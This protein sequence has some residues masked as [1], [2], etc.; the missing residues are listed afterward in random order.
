MN[1]LKKLKTLD[2]KA[3]RLNV[4]AGETYTMQREA[5]R[6]PTWL[7]CYQTTDFKTRNTARD[8]EGHF[9]MIQGENKYKQQLSTH[10]KVTR[11]PQNAWSKHWKENST[12]VGDFKILLSV[13]D[14]TRKTRKDKEGSLPQ[15]SG[16]CHAGTAPWQPYRRPLPRCSSNSPRLSMSWAIMTDTF[17][18][19][20]T[21][22]SI[23]YDHN[24]IILKIN[25][26]GKSIKY[27]SI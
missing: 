3:R 12:I 2:W 8:R 7:H 23:S 21:K 6:E 11:E 19:T 4:K 9:L 14:R 5:S 15:T 13:T 22:Q 20:E 1:G 25:K 17:Q 26:T 18:Q 10:T 24:G 27:L 16:T